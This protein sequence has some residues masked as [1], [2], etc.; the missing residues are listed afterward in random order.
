M[1]GGGGAMR[2]WL[3]DT[4]VYPKTLFATKEK[5]K[6]CPFENVVCL[7]YFVLRLENTILKEVSMSRTHPSDSPQ[8]FYFD[9]S[10]VNAECQSDG[11]SDVEANVVNVSYSGVY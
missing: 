8:G 9:G 5:Y 11:R 10:S 7:L 4:C 6:L 3:T 2:V 1:G